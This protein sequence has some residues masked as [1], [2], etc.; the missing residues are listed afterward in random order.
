MQYKIESLSNDFFGRLHEY[1]LEVV[2]HLL[3]SML[4]YYLAMMTYNR[5]QSNHLDASM[6]V[7]ALILHMEPLDQI[8]FGM[9]QFFL[10][11]EKL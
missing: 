8:H 6:N 7:P 4:L 5:Q 10:N 3:S 1:C 9:L 11:I 2:G